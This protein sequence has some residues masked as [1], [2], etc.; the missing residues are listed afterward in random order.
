MAFSISPQINVYELDDTLNINTDFQSG[1][2]GAMAGYS[3]WGKV[4]SPIEILTGLDEFT[5]K[6]FPPVEETSRSYHIA[7]DFLQYSSKLMFVRIVGKNARNAAYITANAD[8]AHKQISVK[9]TDN[10]VAIKDTTTQPNAL[11]DFGVSG[12]VESD[13]TKR[14]DSS[15][16]TSIQFNVPEGKRIVF[17]RV[18]KVDEP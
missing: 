7:K 15:A 1:I 3:Q 4:L 13:V 11:V 2:V 6:T 16:D 8:V 10:V 14:T 17:I 5:N 18:T 12:L 9:T